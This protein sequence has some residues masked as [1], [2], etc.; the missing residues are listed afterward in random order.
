MYGIYTHKSLLFKTF[1]TV[2][3]LLCI[4]LGLIFS[5]QIISAIDFDRTFYFPV[6]IFFFFFGVCV[7]CFIYNYTKYISI[8]CSHSIDKKHSVF[9]GPFFL[10][11][12]PG[13]FILCHKGFL[14]IIF[15][16]ALENI[17]D[18]HDCIL[19]VEKG[20]YIEDFWCCVYCY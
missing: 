12:N 4:S 9:A 13:F 6:T 3:K 18:V 19:S 17:K 7:L 14:I 2:F 15:V 16:P 10:F 1:Q 8:E 5:T 11:D 20:L